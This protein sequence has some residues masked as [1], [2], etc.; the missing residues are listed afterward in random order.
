MITNNKINNKMAKIDNHY[1]DLCNKIFFYC[2]TYLDVNRNI[3]CKKFHTHTFNVC[4]QSVVF[5]LLTIRDMKPFIRP[6]VAELLWLLRGNQ[7]IKYLIDQGVN[8]RNKDAYKWYLENLLG[9]EFD[10]RLSFDE[11]I[12]KIK[13][14]PINKKKRYDNNY[15][16]GDTGINC[17]VQ[18]R[19]LSNFEWINGEPYYQGEYDQFKRLMINLKKNPMS[20]KHIVTAW[21]PVELDMTASPPSHWSFEI[22]PKLLN[23]DDIAFKMYREHNGDKPK[24]GF[25]LKYHQREVDAFSELPLSIA[26]YALLAEIIGRI[27][28]MIPLYVTCDLS[29]IYIKESDFES[30]KEELEFTYYNKPY[31]FKFSKNA[32]KKLRELEFDTFSKNYNSDNIFFNFLE[33]EDF[34]FES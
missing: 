12:N 6:I 34:I 11:F 10:E 2:D 24:Y 23:E 13:E 31:Y 15:E 4:L 16:I 21:N 17:G 30:V 25:T 22:I 5:P 28:N 20:K 1:K 19:K 33:I 8:T 9:N 32:D 3:K 26:T 7:N 27:C 29:N 18:W 14:K